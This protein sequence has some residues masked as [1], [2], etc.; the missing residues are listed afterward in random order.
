MPAIRTLRF[1]WASL[2]RESTVTFL[3]FKSFLLLLVLF[4]GWPILLR[5][6]CGEGGREIPNLKPPP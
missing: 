1:G 3:N 2:M 5:V 6:L 4:G